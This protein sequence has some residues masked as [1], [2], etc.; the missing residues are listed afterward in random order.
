MNKNLVWLSYAILLLIFAAAVYFIKDS[1]MLL[2]IPNS[3]L[4]AT[5][6]FAD[7]HEFTA[8]KNKFKID[9]PILPQHATET[10]TDPNNHKK[11]IYDMY[12]SE[13]NDGTIFMINLIT[14]PDGIAEKEHGKL[15]KETIDNLVAS[16]SKNT[17]VDQ[18]KSTFKGHDTTNFII[19][20]DQLKMSGRA[21]IVDKTL[22]FQVV[23]SK[24]PLFNKS[25]A[26]HFLN[27]LSIN[28]ETPFITPYP[29]Q[30]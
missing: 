13:K 5:Q 26:D 28:S 16:N 27:S 6:P 19:E 25:E 17:L 9:V 3:D 15:I 7:W 1:F 2:P 8:D 30:P 11:R 23:I 20:N 12:V 4:T 14:Y 21:F 24:I 29:P 10:D 22:F 18:A